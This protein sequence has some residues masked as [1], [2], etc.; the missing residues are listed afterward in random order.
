LNNIEIYKD[1]VTTVLLQHQIAFGM[2]MFPLLAV[3]VPIIRLLLV[4]LA[5]IIMVQDVMTAQPRLQIVLV[6]EHTAANVL[7]V[8]HSKCVQT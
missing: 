5:N 4:R 8:K 7:T 1:F 2:E 6:V 3:I